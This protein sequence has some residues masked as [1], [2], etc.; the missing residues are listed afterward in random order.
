MDFVR[1]LMEAGLPYDYAVKGYNA[2]MSTIANA[3]VNGQK[4]YLGNV[5]CL[6][7]TVRPPRQVRMGFERQQGNK[8]VCKTR[9][10]NLDSR[11]RYRFTLFRKFTETH[12]LNWVA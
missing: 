4:V 8:V 11:L 10:F 5:G 1:K 3:V 7:P 2:M 6:N 9:E 12:E